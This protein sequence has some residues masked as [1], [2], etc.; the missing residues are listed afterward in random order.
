VVGLAFVVTIREK[1]IQRL[2]LDLR[3]SVPHRHVEHA[4][5]N[6]ALAVSARL[7]VCHRDRPD[8]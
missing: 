8:A 3:D 2:L 7:F 5:R 6:R 1:A 4:D